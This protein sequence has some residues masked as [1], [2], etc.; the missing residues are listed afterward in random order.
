MNPCPEW[1]E[2]VALHAGLDLTPAETYDVELH[3]AQ[4]ANCGYF[5]AQLR[6]DLRAL[7]D[8]HAKPIA[9][10]H[11]TALRA[12]VMERVR[13]EQ[14]AVP[15]LRLTW[16]A[17]FAAAALFLLVSPRPTPRP[18]IAKQQLA[19]RPLVSSLDSSHDRAVPRNPRLRRVASSR[20]RKKQPPI[21]VARVVG[22]PAPSQNQPI[23]VKLLTND[24]N[25]VIYWITDPKGE[26]P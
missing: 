17:A 11:Y 19:T 7:R 8:D 15:W 22:P 3:L 14:N 18:P 24:P 23:V 26:L 10:A 12:R 1:Q 4:C 20:R 25:I 9:P 2:R 13:V 6:A 5:A 16:A 21:L